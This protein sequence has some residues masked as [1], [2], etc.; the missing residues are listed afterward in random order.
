M[1]QARQGNTLAVR[2]SL[3]EI[4]QSIRQDAANVA[5]KFRSGE[6][7]IKPGSIRKRYGSS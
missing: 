5:A 2:K 6:I 1:E 4:S 3:S 7:R